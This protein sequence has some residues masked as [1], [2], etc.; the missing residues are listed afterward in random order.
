MSSPK[1]VK[2]RK[3]AACKPRIAND[4]FIL[5][6]A[7]GNV[8]ESWPSF[9]VNL[10]YLFGITASYSKSSFDHSPSVGCFDEGQNVYYGNMKL[11]SHLQK[12]YKPLFIITFVLL[13]YPIANNFA[14]LSSD[15]VYGDKLAL[16][17]SPQPLYGFMRVPE[18][19]GTVQFVAV[20]RLAADFAQIYFRS[21]NTS[22]LNND[23]ENPAQDPWGRPTRYAPTVHALCAFTICKL[24]YGYASLLHVVMQLLMFYLSFYFAFR[25]LKIEKAFFPSILL[26]NI[27]LFL[28]PTG[29]SWIERGQFSLYVALS[30]LW[31]VLGLIRHNKCYIFLS[32]FFAYLK[33]TSLPLLLV[34]SSLWLLNS[35]NVEELKSNLYLILIF[36]FTIIILFSI[37]LKSGVFFLEG[38]F[39]QEMNASPA[40]PSLMRIFPA[41]F[42]K[43][44][45]FVL[46]VFGYLNIRVFKNQFIGLI[47]FFIG[48]GVVLSIY[49]TLAWEYNVPTLLCFI[50]LTIYWSKAQ[51]N[52]K[53]VIGNSIEYLLLLFFFLASFSVYFRYYYSEWSSLAYVYVTFAS[54]FITLPL[55]QAL[56]QGSEQ[57][58][59]KPTTTS[60]KARHP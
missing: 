60:P 24:D 54:L 17:V 55:L 16:N 35:K 58:A 1:Q 15:I 19:G 4:C 23:Y 56:L 51:T 26:L 43:I 40:G 14:L 49:P 2:F 8:R 5:I 21:K 33:W 30:Y 31:L 59:S 18:N 45:P 20:D 46:I 27:C 50:P 48:S 37:Y 44:L 32:A 10:V 39:D 36:P 7:I 38:M 25:I 47:P 53:Q 41:F 22:N 57:N 3:V 6:A 28:T 42:V 11:I 12:F 34:I 29:L 9:D 52:N 13:H